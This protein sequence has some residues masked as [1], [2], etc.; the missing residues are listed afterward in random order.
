MTHEMLH[1]II[2][3][4][5]TKLIELPPA[6]LKSYKPWLTRKQ[7]AWLLDHVH[8]L[9]L[10]DEADIAARLLIRRAAATYGEE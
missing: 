9:R 5:L 8:E 3:L 6:T 7:I 4:A 2:K 10:E 1:A